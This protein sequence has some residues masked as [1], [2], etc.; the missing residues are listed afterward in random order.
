M[1]LE[2]IHLGQ[3]R[4]TPNT[5]TGF[6]ATNIPPTKEQTRFVKIQAINGAIWIREDGSAATIASGF[7]L[8]KNSSVEIWGDQAI[9]DFR[10]IRMGGNA[11]LQCEYYGT[12]G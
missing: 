7:K 9:Q 11:E 5:S 6:T 10:C 3:E 4:L 2:H 12:G 8:P 1:S